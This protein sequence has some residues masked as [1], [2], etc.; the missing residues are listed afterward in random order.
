MP[1]KPVLSDADK[2]AI[3]QRLRELCEESWIAQGYK[4]TSIKNLCDQAAISIGTFYT[5]YPAKEDLFFETIENIQARLT[6]SVLAA[7]RCRQTK[8]GFAQSIKDLCREYD[9]KPFLYHVN[10]PDFQAFLTK[11]PEEAVRKIKF[12]SFDVFR[13]AVQAASLTLKVEESQAFGIL[14]ALLSTIHAK[15]T[16]SVTCDYFA[17]FDRMT[18][19]LVSSIFQ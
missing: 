10:T 14:S 18:D 13:Q 4:K 5:L 3:R 17:V 11:L 9:R 15:E 12:D 1:S 7:N 8:E 6:K 16:L 19:T 2:S